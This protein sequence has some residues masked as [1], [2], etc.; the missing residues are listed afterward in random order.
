MRKLNR[1]PLVET[2]IG[3][4]GNRVKKDF[5][6][7]FDNSWKEGFEFEIDPAEEG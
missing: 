7:E 6:S 2:D 3:D 4:P 5:C 1:D